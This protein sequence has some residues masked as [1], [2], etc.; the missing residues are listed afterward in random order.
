MTLLQPEGEFAGSRVELLNSDGLIDFAV[1][2]AFL[3]AA[4]VFNV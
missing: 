4:F 3:A 2:L 1:R